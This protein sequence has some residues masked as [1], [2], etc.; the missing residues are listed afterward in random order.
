MGWIAED[1]LHEGYLVPQFGDGQRGA[2]V[3]GGGIPSD[4][5][6]IGPEVQDSEGSWVYPTRP[7]GEVTGWVVCCDCSSPTSFGPIRTW[8]GPVFTR[9]PSKAL[10]DVNAQKAFAVDEDVTGFSDREDVEEAALDLWR[11]EHAFSMDALDEVRAATAAAAAT[12]ERLDA[13]VT[14]ARAAGAPWEAIGR[15]AGMPKQSAQGR[16]GR[17]NTTTGSARDR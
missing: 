7:A 16:W 15:S 13:A 9:V 2:G 12:R 17:S 10:E 5:V 11:A 1:G 8:V 6:V 4:R 14:I 3:T